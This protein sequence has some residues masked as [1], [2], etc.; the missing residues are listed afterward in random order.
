MPSRLIESLGTTDEMAELF[1]DSSILG[2]MLQFEVVLAR[3][4][5]RLGIIPQRAAEVIARAAVIQ[6]FDPEAIAR[7]ARHSATV[8]IPFLAA[9]TARAASIDK[10]SAGFVHWGSTSQDVID[11][12]LILLLGRAHTLM[13]AD[14]RRLQSG[15]HALSDRH[16]DSI[17]LSRTVLQPAPPITFGYKVAAWFGAVHRAWRRLSQSFGE[18]S[19]LQFGG[20]AGTLAAYRDRGPALAAEVG[21]ELGLTVPEAPWHTYRDRLAA[22]VV[23]AGIYTGSLGKIAGDVSLLMQAEVGE[24]VERGGASSAMPNKRNPSSSVLV[25]AAA[26]RVP[27]M[28]ASCLS[29]M[30]QEHERAAGGWQAEWPIVGGVIQATG[31]AL[32]ALAEMV[33]GLEVSPERMRANIAATQGAIFAE[34]AAMLLTPKLGRTGAR[35]LVA[36]AARDQPLREGLAQNPQA[37]SLLTPQQIAAIDRPEEY[38]GA[39]EIF[40]R[41]LLGDKE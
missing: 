3:A 9:L 36:E 21:K 35:L 16:A 32:A 13:T 5:A 17:M 31:S 26:K 25:L 34:K 40:R 29:G 18:V 30:V 11:T 28:V 41:R 14:H 15:L 38:L 33:D 37:A 39:A 12:A 19:Q 8:A 27:G 22:V 7:D 1:S 20:A 10:D 24:V 6:D 23:D 2:A 4:Q